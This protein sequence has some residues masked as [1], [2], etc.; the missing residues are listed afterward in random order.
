M[1]ISFVARTTPTR[2]SLIETSVPTGQTPMKEKNL[3]SSWGSKILPRSS[4]I[5]SWIFSGG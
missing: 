5:S 3:S 4:I 2:P 1:S